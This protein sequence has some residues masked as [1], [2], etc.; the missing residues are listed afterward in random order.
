MLPGILSAAALVLA[1]LALFCG[2]WIVVPVP[3][4]ALAFLAVGASELSAWLLLAG[5]AGVGLGVVS[6]MR[7]LG[8]DSAPAWAPWAAGLAVACGGPAVALAMVPPWLARPVAA[9]ARVALSPLQALVGPF[10]GAPHTIASP[11]THGTHAG[12]VSPASTRARATLPIP[13]PATAPRN[14]Q[15]LSSLAP[16]ARSPSTRCGAG[17]RIHTPHNSASPLSVS[18]ATAVRA[19]T[20]VHTVS[21]RRAPFAS[22]STV[23]H[24]F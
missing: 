8:G 22:G 21:Q 18:P 4:R 16:T 14:S 7:V 5:A 23:A 9:E 12:A 17:T 6:V 24:G 13:T 10:A 15:A 20:Y 1:M 2:L 19:I 3:H 11:A